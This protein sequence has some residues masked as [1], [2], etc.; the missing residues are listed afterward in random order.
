MKKSLIIYGIVILIFLGN[1]MDLSAQASTK[2]DPIP[3]SVQMGINKVI[4]RT[5]QNETAVCLSNPK[6]TA[7]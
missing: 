1:T 2:S 4:N 3:S 5:D 6:Y 7:L